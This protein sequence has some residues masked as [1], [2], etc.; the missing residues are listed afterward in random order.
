MCTFHYENSDMELRDKKEPTIQST[1]E[2]NPTNQKVGHPSGIPRD[3]VR[4]FSENA[5]FK[6]MKHGIVLK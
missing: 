6:T 2:S 3:P 5:T 4:E 1:I